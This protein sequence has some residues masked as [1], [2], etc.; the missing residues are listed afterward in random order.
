MNNDLIE[1]YIYAVTKRMDRRQRD[2]VAQELRTLID[3]MLAERCGERKAE[4][5]DIR[6]VLTELGTPQELYAQYDPDRDKCLIGQP[7]Y[8]TYKFVMKIVLTAVAVGM[9]VA[10]LILALIEPQDVVPGVLGWLNALWNSGFGCFAFITL[11]FAFFQRKGVRVTEPFSFEEL[12][13]VP[14]RTQE[15]SRWE[16]IAGIVICLIFGVVVIF[17]PEVFSVVTEGLT[18]SLFDPQAMRDSWFVVLGFCACGIYREVVQL[19]ELKDICPLEEK[20]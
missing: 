11:L 14:K 18:V 9:T 12:P 5:K 16:S 7:Y 10:H 15:I 13:P 8:S 17:T 2:D 20:L 19:M 4:E 1:R 3:D 6:V